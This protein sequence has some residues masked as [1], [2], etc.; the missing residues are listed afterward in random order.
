MEKL[1]KFIGGTVQL[2]FVSY[3]LCRL[4]LVFNSFFESILFFLESKQ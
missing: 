1:Q 2:L 3:P 4:Y